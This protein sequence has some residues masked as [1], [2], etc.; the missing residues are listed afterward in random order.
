MY[1]SLQGDA[2]HPS[3]PWLTA[4]GGSLLACL[5]CICLT[6]TANTSLPDIADEAELLGRRNKYYFPDT[7]VESGRMIASLPPNV[8]TS[9]RIDSY[10][11]NNKFS[12][13]HMPINS[14][15]LM[16]LP[17]DVSKSF[18]YHRRSCDYDTCSQCSVVSL[19]DVSRFNGNNS[20]SSDYSSTFKRFP[21]EKLRRSLKRKSR[22]SMRCGW[23]S[24]SRRPIRQ[25]PLRLSCCS[26]KLESI[27]A[28]KNRIFNFRPQ[29]SAPVQNFSDSFSVHPRPDE[30]DDEYCTSTSFCSLETRNIRRS[31]S[32]VDVNH[33]IKR[34]PKCARCENLQKDII[35]DTHLKR[36]TGKIIRPRKTKINLRISSSFSE[37]SN[38]IKNTGLSVGKSVAQINNEHGNSVDNIKASTTTEPKAM[39]TAFPIKA[40]IDHYNSVDKSQKPTLSKDPIK[41]INVT[42]K[43]RPK[44]SND[45][46]LRLMELK[47]SANLTSTS[48]LF[49]DFSSRKNSVSETMFDQI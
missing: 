11:V 42:K 18:R 14:R 22:S 8:H 21:L 36:I 38:K 40:K 30:E 5:A 16:S 26:K 3:V 2:T 13:N 10:R 7:E 43:S 20:D 6:E 9:V 31:K 27:Y 37:Y 33:K 34:W 47:K 32:T 46:K 49:E 45:I 25:A 29:W 19:V 12:I 39:V 17:E 23:K 15:I 1:H 4:T 41:I 48:E 35:R 44:V 24:Y 28:E